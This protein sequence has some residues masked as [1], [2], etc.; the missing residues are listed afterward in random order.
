MLFHGAYFSNFTEW[1]R[2]PSAVKPSSHVVWSIIGQ[3]TLNFDLGGYF[4]GI[5]TTSGLFHFWR[6]QSMVSLLHLKFASFSSLLAALT[7]L[8]VPFYFLHTSPLRGTSPLTSFR[9]L[10][11]LLGLSSV[12]WA[13]HLL[14]IVLPIYRL[15]NTGI[16]P[17]LLTSP[18]SLLSL[19]ALRSILPHFGDSVYSTLNTLSSYSIHDLFSGTLNSKTFSSPS[20]LTSHHMYLGLT[21]T[22]LGTSLRNK[23]INSSASEENNTLPSSWHFSLSTSLLLSSTLCFNFSHL[24]NSSSSYAFLTVD[25]AT[26]LSLY[27]HYAWISGIF[28]IG[29]SAH[30]SIFFMLD[31]TPSR[32]LFLLIYL[33][34]SHRD[35]TIG[36]LSW[37]IL[38]LGLHSFGL[39]IHNDTLGT[40]GRPEDTFSDASLQLKPLF[41]S[42]PSSDS[43]RSHTR[44]LAALR[45]K[46]ASTSVS[47]GTSDFMLHHIHAFTLHTTSLILLKAFFF[48]RSSRLVSDKHLLGFRYPCDGPGRGGTCQISSWDHIF[49]SLFW[50]YNATSILIF[51]MYWK[52]QSDTWGT[53]FTSTS[54]L[55]LTHLTSGD[56]SSNSSTING[57]LRTF[58]WSQ[59]SQVIQSY[60]TSIAA[61]GFLF[62]G[63]HLLWAFSLMFLYSGRGYWQELIESLL[64]SHHKLNVTPSIQPRALSISQGRSVGVTHYVLGGI[65]CTWS[66]FISRTTA[67]S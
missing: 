52:Y 51:H 38:F 65:G 45:R 47:L 57:W 31:F 7:S 59:S 36:H 61:Y 6:S 11:T 39:Y 63:S 22:T 41:S 29:A 25:Y 67:L 9:S 49:L 58:L 8:Y 55:T 54:L 21:L 20:P 15:L 1:I 18:Q 30:F 3:D 5:Y 46:I 13:A 40:L 32:Q 2:D 24:V 66:F 44:N 56:F 4:Q 19:P 62:L 43:L 10:L 14:H 16:E 37:A 64:W 48:S 60:G 50:T 17:A 27:C 28:L 34:L 23:H 33:A 42:P 26:T 53:F 35:L 12:S